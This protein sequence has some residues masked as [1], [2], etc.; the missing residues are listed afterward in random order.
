MKIPNDLFPPY[1][2]NLNVRDRMSEE[3]SYALRRLEFYGRIA[4]TYHIIKLSL[5][6]ATVLLPLIALVILYSNVPYLSYIFSTIMLMSIVAL[7]T[8]IRVE[9]KYVAF[10]SATAQAG[11]QWQEWDA[12]LE[13]VH[14]GRT[15]LDGPKMSFL[16]QRDRAIYAEII[17]YGRKVEKADEV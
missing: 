5:G 1:N 11:M 9:T 8:K 14:N 13:E 16:R 7:L 10:L 3:A 12:V 15:D 17:Q 6:I 4:G 2:K